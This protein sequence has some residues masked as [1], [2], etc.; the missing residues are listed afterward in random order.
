MLVFCS[1]FPLVN[2]FAVYTNPT[3]ELS[4]KLIFYNM[5]YDLNA[6]SWIHYAILQKE[7]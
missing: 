3:V 5:Y 6:P 4:S 2:L 7:S 1:E